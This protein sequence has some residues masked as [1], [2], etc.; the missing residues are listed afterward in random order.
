[1]GEAFTKQTEHNENHAITV[2]FFMLKE[3]VAKKSMMEV[4]WV[5][6]ENFWNI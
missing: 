2:K 1:M 3:N 4:K 5:K 6:H